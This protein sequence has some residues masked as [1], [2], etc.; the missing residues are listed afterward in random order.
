MTKGKAISTELREALWSAH[1][2]GP[3]IHKAVYEAAKISRTSA[4]RVIK[5]S[6]NLEPKKRAGGRK[7]SVTE[8]TIYFLVSKIK[9]SPTRTL[10]ELISPAMSAEY[11]EIHT[12]TLHRHLAHRLITYKRCHLQPTIRNSPEIKDER[13][14]YTRTLNVLETAE[15]ARQ[16]VH[17]YETSVAHGQGRYYGRAPRGQPVTDHVASGYLVTTSVIGAISEAQGLMRYR[18][19]QPSSATASATCV[20]TLQTHTLVMD[21]VQTHRGQDIHQVLAR[22]SPASSPSEV[23]GVDGTHEVDT[24]TACCVRKGRE[25]QAAGG[26]RAHSPDPL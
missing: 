22:C 19:T 7:G 13:K 26:D 6:P 15:P 24:G 11:P 12:S 2:R 23:W 3:A 1:L 4:F 5:N 25:A 17:I 21:D 18:L 16:R 20:A 14:E 9:E 8:E 10:N